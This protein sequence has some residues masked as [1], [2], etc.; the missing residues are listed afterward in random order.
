[1]TEDELI[2][3][4]TR[5]YTEPHRRYHDLGHVAE[6]LCKGAALELSNEQV[7]AI[8]FHDAIYVPGSDANERES[9][10][11]AVE[12]LTALGWS[13]KA[14]RTVEQIVLDTDGH[15]P[16]IEAS[17]PVL[18][19]DLSPLA[20][21]WE[22]YQGNGRDIRAELGELSDSEWDAGRK[23]WLT[24]ML[25]RERLYWTDWGAALEA[26]ARANLRGDLESIS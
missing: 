9:A 3:E 5:R 2:I 19:L 17:K 10:E 24:G 26:P 6:L 12:R 1:M 16:T 25:E 21:S 13:D 18:D 14:V 4:L 15:V 20:A 23:Q 11:L 7:M 22:V 8:W